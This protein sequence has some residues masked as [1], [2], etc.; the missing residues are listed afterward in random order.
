MS[1][2]EDK[3][4]AF[5]IALIDEG[6]DNFAWEQID[7]AETQEEL[8]EKEKHWVAHYKS[9]N[10]EF[11]YNIFEGGKNAKHTAETSKKISEANSNPSSETRKKHS[12]A[13]KGKQNGLGYRHTAESC[14]KMSERFRGEKSTNV[15]ITETVARQIKLDLQAG[16]RNCDIAR[17]YGVSATIVKDIKSGHS[18]AWLKTGS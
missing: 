17:K 13:M 9:N 3:R 5:G 12:D 15:K 10:P 6:F 11:G 4:T 8:N 16:M 18:W 2:K 14:K 7:S 1:L